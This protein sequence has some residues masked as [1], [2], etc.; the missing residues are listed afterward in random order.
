[1][2]IADRWMLPDGVEELLPDAAHRVEQ[3]RRQLLDLVRCWGYE[4]VMPS[5]IEYTESLLI[6]LGSEFESRSFKVVDELSGRLMAIRP[7]ITPQVARIDAHSLQ[8]DG[9][10]RLCYADTVL[11]TRP[12]SLLASRSPIQMGAEFYGEP[13]VASDIEILCLMLEA[14]QVAGLQ[15]LSIDLGHVGILK[16]LLAAS[17]IGHELQPILLDALQRKAS[18]EIQVLAQEMIADRQLQQQLVALADLYG[19]RSLLERAREVMRGAPA[20][21]MAALDYLEQ[22]VTEVERR[23][24]GVDF[25]FDLAQ[26]RGYHYHTGLVFAAYTPGHGQAIANGGRYDDIGKVF[27]RARPA[28]GFTTELKALARLTA[29]QADDDTPGRVFAPYSEDLA[30]WG[31]VQRLRRDGEIVVFGSASQALPVACDRELVLLQ[32]RWQVQFINPH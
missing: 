9:L 14:L 6:G 32:G 12:Q 4:Q 18:A 7:D 27:G 29:S 24:P 5:L 11:H 2:T 26:L 25:Y 22:V 19:D 16:A 23:N 17:G 13:G 3:L 28:T 15:R 21:V 30:L 8:R 31:E 1:M 20:G 10:V